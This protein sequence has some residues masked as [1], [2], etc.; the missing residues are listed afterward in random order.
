MYKFTPNSGRLQPQ[1]IKKKEFNFLEVARGGLQLT[2]DEILNNFGRPISWIL[3]NMSKLLVYY[4]FT[5]TWFKNSNL[6][7]YFSSKKSAETKVNNFLEQAGGGLSL[8][9]GE[10][11]YV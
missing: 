8:I 10:N 5:L 4:A 1:H 6:G 9:F 11:L 7:S 3:P 2:L